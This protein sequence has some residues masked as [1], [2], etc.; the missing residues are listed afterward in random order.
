MTLID[1]LNILED[2]IKA[3][4][5]QYDLDREAA[6][7]F[8]LSSKELHKYESLTGDHLRYKPL[9]AEKV[10]FEYSSLGEASNNKA[11]GKN[12]KRD[13]VVNTD[14]RDK[15]L[16]YNLQ[17]GFVKFKDISNFKELSLDYRET[18]I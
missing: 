12:G 9:V 18:K 13:K 11:K 6:K 10:K 15:N 17:H 5:F 1:G 3:N 14:K 16:F 8:I 4:Q 7:I 2:K